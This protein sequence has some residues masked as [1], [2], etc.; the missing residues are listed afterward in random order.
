MIIGDK[1]EIKFVMIENDSVKGAS[2]KKVIGPE[3]GWENHVMRIVKLE[4]KGYSFNHKHPWEHVNYYIKG[5]GI[6]TIEGEEF[7]VKEGGYTLVPA[8]KQH[9]WKNNSDDVL[10]FICIVPKEGHQ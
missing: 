9:Q 2:M 1:D 6:L 7:V 3:E 8:N 5:E 4:P 10:E